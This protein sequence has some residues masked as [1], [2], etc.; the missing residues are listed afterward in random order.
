ME[1]VYDCRSLDMTLKQLML[2]SHLPNTASEVARRTGKKAPNVHT[3]FSRLEKA[4]I[5][6]SYYVK[7]TRVWELAEKR[8][9]R[10]EDD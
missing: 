4:G 10:R 3:V 6:R 5:L 2:T 8:F 1:R 9:K 7:A